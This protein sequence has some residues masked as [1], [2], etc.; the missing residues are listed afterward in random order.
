MIK[1]I[2]MIIEAEVEIRVKIRWFAVVS[3][4][5]TKFEA[6]YSIKRLNM[7]M[8]NKAIDNNM[9]NISVT[10]EFNLILSATNKIK[11]R[12]ASKCGIKIEWNMFEDSSE[13]I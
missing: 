8:G 5:S 13:E 12:S 1:P 3:V 2:E 11:P 4:L 7:P 9:P 6:M 10:T